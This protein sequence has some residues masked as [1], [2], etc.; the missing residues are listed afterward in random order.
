MALISKEKKEVLKPVTIKLEEGLATRL[1]AYARYL[2]SSRDYVIAEILKYVI[3]RDK[4]FHQ[5]T[6]EKP[7]PKHPEK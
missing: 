1:D 7:A 5:R 4:E 3:D 6:A 2:E